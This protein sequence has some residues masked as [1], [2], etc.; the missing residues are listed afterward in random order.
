MIGEQI[1]KRR[2]ALE[3]S[4]RDLAKATGLTASYLSQLERDRTD[5]SIKSLRKIA[6]ALAVPLLNLLDEGETR[7]PDPV[8]R[9]H[10]RKILRFPDSQVEYQFLTPDINR[11]LEMFMGRLEAGQR[12]VAFSLSHPTEECLL[13]LKG[14]VCVKLEDGE[15]RL[16]AG[17]T[18]YFEGERLQEIYALGDTEAE[19]VSAITP[20]V[21]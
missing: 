6:D 1:K 5:P 10:R 14:R 21:F 3:M 19:F 20:P 15:Y 8:V 13:V 18:I 12:N 11:K 7:R 9:K 16:E 4:Q 2:Q 17:D